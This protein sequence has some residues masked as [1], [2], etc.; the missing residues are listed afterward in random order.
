MMKAIRSILFLV[1]TPTL[2]H[3]AITA[4]EQPPAPGMP[5][6]ATIPSSKE[7]K[8]PNGLTVSSISKKGSPIVT[9]QLV[10]KRGASSE[11]ESKAGLADITAAMLTK[12]TKTRTATQIAEAIEFL[13]GSIGSGAGWNN[14][15]ATVT[16]TS[17]KLPQAM[18]ILA[19]V[20]LNPKFSQEEL[21]LYK[22]Q[23]LDGLTYNLKQPSFLANYAASKYSYG[24][25]P[26]GGTKASIGSI[27]LKDVSDFYAANFHPD[28]AVLIFAGDT[29]S[30]VANSLATRYFGLWKRPTVRAE[31]GSSV[32]VPT[33]NLPLYR[34]MLVIDLP[35]SG[36]ASVVYANKLPS[37]GRLD[38][39][40][41]RASVL[42]SVLGGGYSSRLNYEIRIKRGLS[43]GAGSSFV[44]R[45]STA[46]FGTSVQTK[47]ESAAEVAEL[48]LAELKRMIDVPVAEDELV[49][50]KSVLTGSFGRSLETT[51][52]LAASLTSLYS[53]GIP[54]SALNSHMGDINSVTSSEI[55]EFAGRYLP[56]GDIIICGD[57][58]VFKNDLA[59]RFPGV[60]VDVI[61]ADDLDLSKSDLRK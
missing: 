60:K 49:P 21:D 37:V 9:V 54:T 55:K 12:G 20:V 58:S 13:G 5:R 15:F 1:L 46:N 42:N 36:Q 30:A 22:S 41:Y 24:E 43:Y 31:K 14:S 29:D 34:R 26:A 8:L 18:A 16:V 45:S 52:G 17:D 44:W 25:H 10:I 28:D 38:P 7:K 27:T 47:N 4:Q 19:D 61:A 50:R 33:E 53:F 2:L 51:G 23:A 32:S 57:Y 48:I 11:S 59:K 3:V 6:T 40:F 35:K 56:G 39:Q